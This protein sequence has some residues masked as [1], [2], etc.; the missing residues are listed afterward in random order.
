MHIRISQ[1]VTASFKSLTT[2]G[3]FYEVSFVLELEVISVLIAH[4][5]TA[6]C[7]PFTKSFY[8]HVCP[9]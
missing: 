6:S 5:F 1:I 9:Q 2:T 8:R 7:T 4:F 3:I